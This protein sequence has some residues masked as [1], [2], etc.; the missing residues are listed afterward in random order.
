MTR[1]SHLPVLTGT[2][3]AKIA[4][5]L[6]G[7]WLACSVGGTS[8]AR[9]PPPLRAGLP[10]LH[11]LLLFARDSHF[12]MSVAVE[13][14]PSEWACLR[15]LCLVAIGY[16]TPVIAAAWSSPDGPAPC[17]DI[18]RVG[19]IGR[20]ERRRLTAYL[21]TFWASPS[22]PRTVGS[23]C[24][25]PA[26]LPADCLS[27]SARRGGNT[28]TTSLG[29]VD[30]H[31]VGAEL[32]K[33]RARDQPHPAPLLAVR[34]QAFDGVTGPCCRMPS[35][36][37]GLAPRL[38]FTAQCLAALAHDKGNGMDKQT[39]WSPTLT[40]TWLASAPPQRLCPVWCAPYMPAIRP[41]CLGRGRRRPCGWCSQLAFCPRIAVGARAY[42]TPH[43][44]CCPLLHRCKTSS[45][46]TGPPGSQ[47][48]SGQQRRPLGT[49]VNVPG[50]LYIIYSH[51]IVPPLGAF[52]S[53]LGG[54]IVYGCVFL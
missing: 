28:R 1:C 35:W 13:G 36:W 38:A 11:E 15:A 14:P 29:G 23:R 17:T 21:H 33:P 3:E 50:S 49:C 37:T 5:Q 2:E 27:G 46:G 22:P 20:R 48:V 39:D 16:R 31:Y 41:S 10:L 34:G 24:P 6:S 40:P 43:P 25:S 12:Y 18:G 8:A 45:Y 4:P 54:H 42:P 44:S 26:G 32:V 52:K 51:Y 19:H 9:G 30:G 53:Q 47:G 7:G